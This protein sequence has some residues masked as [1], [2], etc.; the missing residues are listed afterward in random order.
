MVVQPSLR[1]YNG[2]FLSLAKLVKSIATPLRLLVV[3]VPLIKERIPLLR[4]SYLPSTRVTLLLLTTPASLLEYSNNRLFRISGTVTTLTLSPSEIFNDCAKTPPSGRRRVLLGA[5]LFD[6]TN[7]PI[8]ERLLATRW[9][10]Q[11]SQIQVWSL[12]TPVKMTLPF[13]TVVV[14][15]AAFTLLR[16]SQLNDPRKIRLPICRTPVTN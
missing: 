12:L 11:P 15:K 1:S 14:I 7:L 4:G 5:T 2:L 13:M 10:P 6:P 8:K 9:S 16:L 3:P